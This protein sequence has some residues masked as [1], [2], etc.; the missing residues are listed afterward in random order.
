MSLTDREWDD[1]KALLDKAVNKFLGFSEPSLVTAALK[2]IDNGYDEKETADK[3]Q[4]FLDERQAP[5]IAER[6]FDVW[7]SYRS[8]S[9]THKTKRKKDD[10][11]DEVEEVKKKPK[12]TE[13][14]DNPD[15]S[16]GQL[17]EEKIKEMMQNAQKMIQER[18]AQLM[19]NQQPP[20]TTQNTQ[21]Q[22]YMNDAKEKAKRAN[23][24]QAQIQARLANM[25]GLPAPMKG[26]PPV[27]ST[28]KKQIPDVQKA[29]PSS[30][31]TPL[32]LDSEGRTIDAKTGEAITLQHY[33]PTLKANIRAKRREQFK[34]LIDAPPEE[35]S[36]SKFFDP[37]VSGQNAQR[38]KRGFRFHEQGKFEQ[39]A[40]RLR[41]KAQL[42]RL[43][44]EISH[45]AKRTG[46]AS[47]AKLATIAPKQELAAGEIPDVEWW[48]S[49][50]IRTVSSYDAVFEEGT[51]LRSRLEGI[52]HLVEHPIQMKPPDEPEKEPL[53]PMYLTAAE[54][55]KL[56]RQNRTEA[57]KELQ[58]KIRLGLAP[59][60]EPKVRMA[61]LM[62]V[63]GSEAVQD[64][65][66]VEAHVRAQMAKRQRGHEEA[67]AARKLTKEQRR[68]K[69]INKIK[70]DTSLGVHVSVYRVNDLTNP[71]KKFKVETNA[72]QLYMTGIV[73]LFKDCNVVVVEGGPKQQRKFRRLMLHRIKWAEDKQKKKKDEDEGDD[74]DNTNKCV[75]VWEG[76]TVNRAFTEMKFK[77]CPTEAF[78]REQFRK[79]NVES[80]WD[81]AFSGAVLE[82]AGE[83][84]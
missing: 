62:R 21:A 12:F 52:T 6:L 20:P 63:L 24:L 71:A 32:I 1:L 38:Q 64:P 49:F 37:R 56:R 55:K 4:A 53:I 27:K 25:A 39:L 19:G 28:D 42:D 41:T 50:V 3:L 29:L 65:T 79:S 15:P 75:L 36:A 30:Q 23:E 16:P 11:D 35:I 76:T 43:Q 2:C 57:Q 31:P 51:D 22:K 66:K 83:E 10:Y 61:N 54:R 81:L 47:A 80:Y 26:M 84:L 70:E 45:A 68:D 34:G 33:A 7:D 78:A 73:V 44:S 77:V 48:D 74:V 82:N 69:K 5:M 59:P 40:Q 58:E 60:M 14:P 72:N 13:Q 17:T 9:K 67:N 8:S 46:I 18:K